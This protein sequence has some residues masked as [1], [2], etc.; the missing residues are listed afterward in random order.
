MC[1]CGSAFEV[2]HRP[3]QLAGTFAMIFQAV[4]WIAQ[5]SD[6][7]DFSFAAKVCIFFNVW[8]KLVF[9]YYRWNT[10]YYRW[11][12]R[13]DKKHKNMNLFK[14][15]LG[16]SKLLR[17]I[18]GC[19]KWISDKIPHRYGNPIFFSTFIFSS[20]KIIL[21]MKNVFFCRLSIK[22]SWTQARLHW[23][24]HWKSIKNL[25]K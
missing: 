14:W 1:T 20:R 15:W 23:E 21:K 25:K 3:S 4:S 13:S 10:V 17:C 5:S 2:E 12:W 24:F 18:Y 19:Q 8:W 7:L 6:W 11:S 9:Q 22:S 16:P